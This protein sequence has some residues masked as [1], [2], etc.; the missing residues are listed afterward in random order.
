MLEIGQQFSQT[1]MNGKIMDCYTG[2]TNIIR[3][4][5]GKGRTA[6]G[7]AALVSIA[8]ASK[9]GSGSKVIICTDGL[10]NIGIG[11]LSDL[12]KGR[13]SQEEIDEFY[14]KIASLANEHGVT[15]DLL[16]MKGE[17]WDLETLV[18]LTDK[19]GGDVDIINPEDLSGKLG[20]LISK[21][22]IATKVKVKIHLHRAF[23]FKNENGLHMNIDKTLLIKKI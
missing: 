9:L 17:E 12:A 3:Q 5:K 14:Q 20:L 2:L 6:L 18:T 11:N 4:I 19:T 1:H 15:V 22:S 10:S 7:P 21:K 23:E 16:S 8:A 13:V